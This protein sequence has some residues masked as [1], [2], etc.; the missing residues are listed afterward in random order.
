MPSFT[1]PYTG[2]R[3]TLVWNL[4]YPEVIGSP[5]YQ[6]PGATVTY[7]VTVAGAN[8]PSSIS[9]V[10]YKN[11]SDVTATVMPSGSHSASGQVITLKPLTAL[12]A[13]TDYSIIVTA[14]IAGNTEQIKLV[15]QGTDPKKAL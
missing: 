7:T 4:D 10:V 6:Y 15:V 13:N 12:V 2:K 8:A 3:T 1:S 11:G 9:A 5:I 14:T